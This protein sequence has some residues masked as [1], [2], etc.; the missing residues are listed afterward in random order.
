MAALQQLLFERRVHFR[1]AFGGPGG[2]ALRALR[3]ATCQWDLQSYKLEFSQYSELQ[4]HTRIRA[5]HMQAAIVPWNCP[6]DS[7]GDGYS[8]NSAVQVRFFVD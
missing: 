1:R 7:R 4:R 3:R 6:I 8:V 2:P 5:A